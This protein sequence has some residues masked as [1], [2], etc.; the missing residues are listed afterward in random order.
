[1]RLRTIPILLALA[2]AVILA[3]CGSAETGPA[4]PPASSIEGRA[5]LATGATS[6]GAP[7]GLIGQVSVDFTQPGRIRVGT[8][9]NSGS[10]PGRIA[11]GRLV[12]EDLAVTAMGC[13]ADLVAQEAFVLALVGSRPTVS[14][15]GDDL[16]LRSDAAEVRFLDRRVADPD[17][18]LEGT[19]WTIDG[20]FD[21]AIASSASSSAGRRGFLVIEAGRVTGST[22]CRT[23]A[24]PATVSG[25]EVT[26]G[27]LTLAGPP[28]PTDEARTEAAV[29]AV[30]EGTASASITARS[31]RLTKPDGTGISL[32]GD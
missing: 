25:A 4:A 28:C 16:V 3:A 17:R 30:L 26:F 19:R 22:G 27:P 8:G 21:A 13:P 11:D 32:R 20:T 9:C 6:E 23:F 12:I 5:F 10:G 15:T 2:G 24:G 29:L 18:P 1:M 14:L 31:L 7:H